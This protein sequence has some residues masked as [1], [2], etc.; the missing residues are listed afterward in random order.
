MEEQF[1]DKQ[2]NKSVFEKMVFA[3]SFLRELILEEEEERKY[4]S[5]FNEI[6]FIIEGDLS[7]KSLEEGVKNYSREQMIF[8]FPGGEVLLKAETKSV[9]FIL[10]LDENINFCEKFSLHHLLS[11]RKAKKKLYSPLPMNERAKDFVCSLQIY[12]NDE[13][14]SPELMEM[15]VTE[16]YYLLSTYYSK[17]QLAAFFSPLLHDNFRFYEFVLK[18][19][20]QV[21]TAKELAALSGY[22]VTGFDRQFRA[23]FGL[24]PYQWM[25]RMRMNKII[26][27]LKYTS[28]TLEEIAGENGFASLDAF[29]DF[30]KKHGGLAPGMIRTGQPITN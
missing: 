21:K 5:S 25:L 27:E 4:R 20:K 13:V 2:R 12:M 18:H 10:R 6:L 24:S 19:Y 23:M 26:R 30:C 11:L 17:E 14:L 8:L 15:K 3:F 1:P 16:Y 22:S 9:C 7:L 29:I 28:K